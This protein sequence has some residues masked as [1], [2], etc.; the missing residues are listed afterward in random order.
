[1][2]DKTCVL[3]F[4]ATGL[5]GELLVRRLACE[6]NYTVV[7]VARNQ[8][9]L[10][11]LQTDTGI[12]T[13]V[14]DINEEVSVAATLRQWSPFAVVDCAGPF[15]FYG[16]DPYCFA[17]QVLHAGSHYIDIAD[18]PAFVCGITELDSLARERSLLA[19]SGASSAPAISAAAVDRLV[20]A[21]QTIALIEIAIVPGNRARR[22]LSVMKA[23]MG[24]IG[25]P[26]LLTRHN[27]QETVHGWTETKEINLSLPA[28]APVCGRLASLV[29]TPE[30]LLFPKRYKAASVAVFAG[31]E[32]RG[33]HRLLQLCG[34]MV[35][36]G[37]LPSLLPLVKPARLI[38][39]GFER[40]GS[41]V[42][43][44]QVRVIGDNSRGQILRRTWDLVAGDGNGPNIPTLPVSVLLDKLDSGLYEA[45]ARHSCGEVSLNDLQT[46]FEA[47]GAVTAI[48][49][50]ELQ[51]M[52]K[53]ALGE[54]F[55]TLPPPVQAL[56][57]KVGKSVY[58]GK[59]KSLGPTGVSGRLA[60][61]IFRFPGAAVNVPVEVTIIADV[62][63]ECGIEILTA[64]YSNHR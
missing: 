3:V 60:A 61:F 21:L 58:R 4:G 2:S 49:E 30:L 47:I 57:N 39:S 56:H 37:V 16:N 5:F 23:I 44:M 22:T 9:R 64:K 1:M 52:F 46:H 7:G 59:A 42:G 14:V 50:E 34:K 55:Q 25:Q 36:T 13:A 40:F 18:A 27:Q 35:Q 12:S 11:A 51:P 24:Q 26:F 28:S 10:N 54:S 32:M 31:L 20:E 15:Q 29:N 6:Q 63:S 43:G 45:G 17:R 38:A 48:N 53:V 62:N 41:D 19:I 8:S 33:F